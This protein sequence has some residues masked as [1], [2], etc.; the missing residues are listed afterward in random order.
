M[1]NLWGKVY[2]RQ[3]ML[4][5]VGDMRQLAYV[6]PFE[7][8]E[9]SERGT[10]AVRLYNASGLDL[11]VMPDRGMSITRLQFQGAPLPFMTSV[12]A[13][14]PAFGEPTGTGWLRTWPG[15]F[16]T[17]C[18]LTQVGSPGSDEG[19]DLGLHGRVAGI[20]AREVRWGADWNEDHY[21][22]WVEGQV[23]QTAFFGEKISLRR[24][25]WTWLGDTRFW[26]EDTVENH[27]FRPVP[28]MLLQ[29][30]NL[31]FPL[32]DAGARLEL[33]ACQSEP[34]D[35]VA[36]AGLETCCQVDH[37]TAGY[38]EQVFFHQLQ[39]GPDGRVEVRL[40]NPDFDFGKGLGVYWRYAL[41]DYP[42]LVE[43]KMMGEGAYVMGVEPSNCHV[44][45][46]ASERS[47]GTLQYLQPF[48]TR[49][50]SMEVGFFR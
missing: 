29:H 21:I 36:R 20:P 2:S 22:L 6:E 47:R 17:P 14:H 5:R 15:G 50:L 7:L 30:F 23:M 25:V 41:Q 9:G 42:N 45:G 33:P 40:S 43:W 19:E 44:S 8:V 26:I 4:R 18:G 24:R 11:V 37:P 39:A 28:F 48:E 32:V 16:S 38:R 46:R 35:E 49:R 10:R 12:G 31:G 34:R 13:V 27:D 3:E 1:P